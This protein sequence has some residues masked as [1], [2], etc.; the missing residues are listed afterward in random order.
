MNDQADRGGIGTCIAQNRFDAGHHALLRRI[1]RG[2]D[3]GGC[4]VMP[5]IE[6]DIGEGAT[7][8]DCKPGRGTVF[9]HRGTIPESP[10]GGWVVH[11]S[12]RNTRQ[13]QRHPGTSGR[14]INRLV[15]LRNSTA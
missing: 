11:V 3:L 4:Q 8:I 5:E 12:W 2:Q 10:G 9:R 7:D 1:G 14:I 13:M 6:N 15:A